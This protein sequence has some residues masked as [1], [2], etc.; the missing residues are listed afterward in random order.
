MYNTQQILK[1]FKQKLA[2]EYPN[3]VIAASIFPTID[4]QHSWKF[5]K[6]QNKLQLHDGNVVHTF[7]SDNLD[8]DD[9]F[10]AL[11]T[12]DGSHFD[13]GKDMTATGT[14]QVHKANPGLLYVTLH[15][16]IK[17][18]TL[19]LNHVSENNWRVS[20]KKKKKKI[21]VDLE[22]L[23]AGLKDK[24][25]FD[26]AKG[27]DTAGNYIADGVRAV[28]KSPLTSTAVGIGLGGAY[29]LGRRAF[30]NTEEENNQE[31]LGQ[32]IA[33][34]VVPGAVAGISGAAMNDLMPNYYQTQPYSNALTKLNKT[35]NLVP[36]ADERGLLSPIAK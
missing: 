36:A 24:I 9:D 19:T 15:D 34:W 10:P 28:G 33:R 8:Q 30:Y 14:A 7:E 26:L 18:P 2:E 22:A 23:K 31:T 4:K 32:R 3:T 25:A 11:K 27:L 17:N 35:P 5:A 16:G 20:P 13:F 12:T 6:S 29:D 21:A 1:G